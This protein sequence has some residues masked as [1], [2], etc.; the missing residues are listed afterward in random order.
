MSRNPFADA[1]HTDAGMVS[2]RAGAEGSQPRRKT[3]IQKL[4]A[5]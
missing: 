2:Y 1:G 4:G 5:T 3:Q